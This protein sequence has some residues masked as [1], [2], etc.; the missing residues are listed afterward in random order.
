MGGTGDCLG[1]QSSDIRC[2]HKIQTETE[3]LPLDIGYGFIALILRK[4]AVTEQRG[5]TQTEELAAHP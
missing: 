4:N 2:C 1:S 5:R 3:T